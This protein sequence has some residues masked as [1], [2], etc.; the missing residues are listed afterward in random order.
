MAT[1]TVLL[2]FGAFPGNSDASVVI[3]GQALI[4]SGSLVEAWIFPIATADH[5]ADE[6][7]LETLRVFAG[8]IVAGTSFTIY[9]FNTS[10]FN[11]PLIRARGRGP[12]AISPNPT[13][14]GQLQSS[15]G[16]QMPTRGGIGTRLY[17]TFNIAWGG[18]Y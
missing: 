2:D 17:G 12:T 4:L 3:G 5:T 13:L 7:M 8:N 15:Q 1:G 9:G 16:F 11:E 6:Q 18:D 10:E 14:A